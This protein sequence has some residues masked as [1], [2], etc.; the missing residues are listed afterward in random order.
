MTAVNILTQIQLITNSILQ[1]PLHADYSL[2]YSS[3]SKYHAIGLRPKPTKFRLFSLRISVRS[4]L[5]V[6]YHP[7]LYFQRSRSVIM[8]DWTCSADNGNKNQF[9]QEVGGET[10]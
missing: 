5:I 8:V 2:Q 4:T 7:R 10:N 6:F 3:P 1:G 9:V